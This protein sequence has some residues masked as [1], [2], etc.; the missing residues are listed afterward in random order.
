[1]LQ[2]V[3]LATDLVIKVWD[4]KG[5]RCVQTVEAKDWPEAQDAKPGS[6]WFDGAAGRLLTAAL[7]PVAWSRELGPGGVAGHTSRVVAALYNS[8]F[9]LVRA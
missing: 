2:V 1:M 4:L 9:D 3:S 5:Q 8:T 7:R 6:I